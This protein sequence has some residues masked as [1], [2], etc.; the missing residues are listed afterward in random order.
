MSAA[1]AAQQEMRMD[2]RHA[3]LLAI[4]AQPVLCS[5]Q[6]AKRFTSA[7]NFDETSS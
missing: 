2:Q 7:E 4:F 3:P 6:L 1:R 5:H